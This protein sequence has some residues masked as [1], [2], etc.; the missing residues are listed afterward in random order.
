MS[1]IISLITDFSLADAY[2]GVMKGVI[3]WIAP[4]AVIIDISH[5]IE[6][7][8][9]FQAA[10]VI[11]SAYCYFPEETVHVVVVDPG[12]GSKRRRIA[13][14]CGKWYFV[15]PDN[16]VFSYPIRDEGI[17]ECVEITAI[18][19]NGLRGR[20][21]DG[22]DVF[23][24]AAARIAMGSA[25][26]ELGPVIDDPITLDIPVA[27]IGKYKIT[28][29]IIY[30]DAFG[31]CIS[32][33]EAGDVER[34]GNRVVVN[35]GETR[36]GEMK[37]AYSDVAHGKTVALINSIGCVEVAVNRGSA[38]EVLGIKVGDMIEVKVDTE[39]C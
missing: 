6:P 10:F 29:Q 11:R 24:P 31:N 20:T 7:Q 32:N 8:N 35:V 5:S 30:I 33:I 21:F 4:N 13:M 26:S 34:L 15:G 16:G 3:L 28:G 39:P 12:V 22:R 2:V 18:E 38:V 14:K 17:G 25:L 36:I 37:T 9:I 27:S 23:A 1:R 19:V